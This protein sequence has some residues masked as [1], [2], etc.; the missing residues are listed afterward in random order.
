MTIQKEIADEYL[1]L[2]NE[3]RKAQKLGDEGL[4]RKL[5]PRRDELRELFWQEDVKSF[6]ELASYQSFVGALEGFCKIRK[7]PFPDLDDREN[8]F[9]GI[10][11][12]KEIGKFMFGVGGRKRSI[13]IMPH[14][15]QGFISIEV[16]E[17][18]ICYK[19]TTT[20]VEEA[21]VVLSKWY[22]QEC[23]IAE[24]NQAFPWMSDI[25]FMLNKPRISFE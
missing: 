23:S 11:D 13:Q 21:A 9:T 24:L 10:G 19:G 7:L 12:W 5:K 1:K 14:E 25:P 4:I 6:P 15:D 16:Y 17:N 8:N 20:S 3:F 2:S 22:M 18:E